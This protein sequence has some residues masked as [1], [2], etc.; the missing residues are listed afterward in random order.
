M[1]QTTNQSSYP[2]LAV[3]SPKKGLADDARMRSARDAA[4]L[5]AVAPDKASDPRKIL[6]MRKG[7]VSKT[8]RKK[9]QN[10]FQLVINR[11]SHDGLFTKK[12]QYIVEYNALNHQ[13][14]F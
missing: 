4:R 12:K 8:W 11:D 5:S 6:T 9:Q 13:Q 2:V 14:V 1:F 3:F 10:A 7:T